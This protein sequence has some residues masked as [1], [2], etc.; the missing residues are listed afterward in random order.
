MI[1]KNPINITKRSVLYITKLCNARCKFCYYRFEDPHTK[2]HLSLSEII[3]TL[4][5]YKEQYGIEYVD[6][7]GGE[8]TIHPN[9][10][11]IVKASCLIGIKPT[12]ITNAQLPNIISKLID[13]GLEDVLVSIHGYK[14]WHDSVVGR[15][16]AFDKILETLRMLKSRSFEFRINTVL[17]KFSCEKAKS[18]ANLYVKLAPRMVNLISF[19]PYEDSLWRDSKNLDFQ[20]DYP[21]QAKA[22]RVII[23]TLEKAGIWVNVRYLPLCFLQGYEEH[24]CN[25]LQ[26]PYDPYEWEYSSYNNLSLEEITSHTG[27]AVKKER[28][29][30]TER[31]QFY[32]HM[33]HNI[34]KDNKKIEKCHKCSLVEIC[35]HIYS[36][37]LNEYGDKGYEAIIGEKVIDSMHFRELDRRWENLKPDKICR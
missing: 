25:F 37:Y 36:Q 19:N 15:Q 16:G 28:F 23:D 22:A 33:M 34:I 29:G 26:L 12:I 7:S 27:K 10:V 35:D 13:N 31:E 8:P 17:T 11:D 9:I 24:V 32:Q 4:E 21:T 6:I 18:L 20:V 1:D 5:K 14:E 3:K 30:K 2:K